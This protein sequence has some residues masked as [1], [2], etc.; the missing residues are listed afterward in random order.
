R[1]DDSSNVFSTTEH[2]LIDNFWQDKPDQNRKEADF[3][4]NIASSWIAI[5]DQLTRS[6][7]L[8]LVQPNRVEQVI[9]IRFA[10]GEWNFDNEQS[11]E[12]NEF[13]RFDYSVDYNQKQRLLTLKFSYHSKAS[14][15]PAEQY[16]EY[17]QALE[18]ADPYTGYGIYT[19]TSETV[20]AEDG[21]SFFNTTTILLT[22]FGLF[23]LVLILW[24]IDR[25]RNPDTE[26]AVFFP[27]APL[28]FIA[29]WVLTFGLYG[30]YWFY[31][32]FRY[33]KEKANN[34]SMPVARGIFYT[35]WY[36]P[37]WD[38]LRE[39]NEQRYQQSHLPGKPIALLLALLFLFSG[40]ASGA[41]ALVIPAV[42]ICALLTLPLVNY[43][44]FV[45]GADSA[46]M[47]KNSRW[48]PRHFL[49]VVL[50]LPL[51]VLSVGSEIGLLPNDAVI[52]GSRLLSHDLQF[53]QRKGIIK[54]NDHIEYFY[55]DA[56]FFIQEDGNGFT[57]RHVFS[58]WKEGGSPVQQELA[59][60]KDIEKIDVNWGSNIA[61]NSTVT[62]TRKDGSEF[63]LFVSTVDRQ[64][65]V[66]VK[67]LKDNW[68]HNRN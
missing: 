26:E 22:Y 11:Q 41:D 3:F 1:D 16:Q 59:E 30:A 8:Y 65:S 9:E 37:L 52:K 20:V 49:L 66:F 44:A 47:A 6:H 43:I 62:I 45:N 36:Y 54:A 51:C 39:D 33:L 42:L 14:V 64:D 10:S 63:L 25:R 48:L 57:E 40:F 19:S 67:K 27:V 34:A 28:K 38:A 7:P 61:E 12:D 58:Y 35:F 68:Q 13:F 5:P 55:S 17:R 23:L 53:M 46:A 32:N 18:R 60:Y 15:V 31:R 2:Y 29:L 56:L 50:S 24:R 4:A 21:A